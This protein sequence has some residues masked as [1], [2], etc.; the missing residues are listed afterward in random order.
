MRAA[1]GQ[2]LGLLRARIRARARARARVSW[3]DVEQRRVGEGGLLVDAA[4]PRE[5]RE[6]EHG[7]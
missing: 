6:H 7:G 5:E 4:E 2:W 1:S 3:P